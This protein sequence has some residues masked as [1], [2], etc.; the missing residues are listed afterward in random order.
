MLKTAPTHCSSEEHSFSN[1]MTYLKFNT[2]DVESYVPELKA[3]GVTVSELV[4]LKDWSQTSLGPKE[5]WSDCF[6]WT[7]NLVLH[8]SFPMAIYYGE[9]DLLLYNQAWSA[10]L[11]TKHPEAFGEPGH[12][13]W[14]EIWHIM[15]PLI[16]KAYETGKGAFLENQ[17]FLLQRAGYEEETWFRF[18]IS[19]IFDTDGK[20][21]GALNTTFEQTQQY[22]GQRRLT[23]LNEVG[24][25]TRVAQNHQEACY[26]VTSALKKNN[27]DVPW[28]MIYY[29]YQ[30]NGSKTLE[31]VTSSF[32]EDVTDGVINPC[33]PEHLV[34][35]KDNDD[36]CP[37]Y[38][39]VAKVAASGEAELIR[40][41]DGTRAVFLPLFI[42]RA[43]EGRISAVMVCGLHTLR[44][45]DSDYQDFF[46]HLAAYVTTA[47][48]AGITCEEEK[49]QIET[50]AE[51]NR[52]KTAFFQNVS[53]ELRT[54]L[55]LILSP[56][57]QTL[58][59]HTLPPKAR[60]NMLMVQ[61]NARRLL[62]LVNTLLEFS[63]I[64]AG[65]NTAA[66]QQTNISQFT[67]ELLSSFESTAV[68]LGVE[69][70][71]N[72]PEMI[73]ELPVY[74]DQD[75]WEKILLN[76]VSNAFKF[77]KSGIVSVS[78]KPTI[79]EMP[80][81][82]TVEAIQLS[83]IDTGI[84]ISKED[85]KHL[86][87]RFYCV[88][89]VEARSYEGTG[90]GLA[91]VQELVR[92]HLGTIDVESKEL[93][94][95][96]FNVTI[97]TGKS[98]ISPEFIVGD[99]PKLPDIRIKK[100]A[101]L[102]L[103][104]MQQWGS[105]TTDSQPRIEEHV[106]LPDS[107]NLP[108]CTLDS[109]IQKPC[110]LLADD[111]SDMR[112]YIYTLLEDEFE[113][114]LATNGLEALE[115]IN[116][117]V[118]DLVLSDVMMPHL[119]GLGLLKAFRENPKTAT[120]P[121]IFLSAR[122]GPAASAEGVE[123]GAD[124]YLIKPFS[125]QELLARVRTNVIL[126]KLRH[127][128]LIQQRMQ[129]ECKQMVL[130]ISGKIRARFGLED[131]LQETADEVR[132]AL[133]AD[134]I[135]IC[136]N[137][138]DQPKFTVKA[139]ALRGNVTT[140]S[141][142]NRTFGYS[143]DQLSE[144]F[145][146]I[147]Q[148]VENGVNIAT[149]FPPDFSQECAF[150][151]IPIM[152]DDESWG[153]ITARH[154]PG[155]EW[156]ELQCTLIQQ[157]AT[158]VALAI[159]HDKL[160][161]EK[162]NQ[163]IQMEAVNAANRAKSVIL[164]NTSHEIRTP[165]NAIIG[166]VSA[167][168]DTQ[169]TL[170]QR[171]MLKIMLTASDVLLRV[172]NDIL[173]MAKLEARKIKLK[174]MDFSLSDLLQ[175]TMNV[176]SK[177]KEEKSLKLTCT[178]EPNVPKNVIGDSA[179]VQ[180]VLMN[181]L[182]NAFK[183]TDQGQVSIH[184]ERLEPQI[185]SSILDTNRITLR[186]RVTD[187]G[188]GIAKEAINKHLFRSFHQIDGSMTRKYDGVGLGLAICKE[189]VEIGEGQIGVE[190]TLGEGSSFWFTWHFTDSDPNRVIESK[191]LDMIHTQKCL[192]IC[193]GDAED[194]SIAMLIQD[195]VRSHVQAKTY[196]EG[197]GL[198]KQ[199]QSTSDPFQCVFLNVTGN[200]AV[201][202]LSDT[203]AK[204]KALDPTLHI[205]LIFPLSSLHLAQT[206]VSQFDDTV[207]GISMPVTKFKLTCA[208]LNFYQEKLELDI[209][210][211][212]SEVLHLNTGPLTPPP[213]DSDTVSPISPITT[214]K[215]NSRK[216]LNTSAKKAP[217]GLGKKDVEVGVVGDAV[218]VNGRYM[219]L[220]VED[221]PVNMEVVHRQLK[222]LGYRST[223][224]KNGAEAVDLLKQAPGD[225]FSLVLMDCAMPIKDGFE[226]TRDVRQLFDAPVRDI[227]IVALSASCIE[228][229]QKECM[230]SGMNDFLA[231]PVKLGELNQMLQKWLTK[232]CSEFQETT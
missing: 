225:Q 29:P 21:V 94:G 209:K 220:V 231:K 180:Q 11:G 172:V 227:P 90:I 129:T 217:G 114:L 113:V 142:L 190:S 58:H 81:G 91:L 157:I 130:N 74:V 204:L 71:I 97:P 110:V 9:D 14:A 221:N 202:S 138:T 210:L 229:T 16:T 69:F 183:F 17:I 206:V 186:F 168:E 169:L 57:E 219:I 56:I 62:K 146:H 47:I 44:L 1:I 224:A 165:L 33:I 207:V 75:M 10:I 189:L 42:S 35:I 83:V 123:A 32:G 194:T 145:R 163:E 19:P 36:T 141:F 84:G 77:T 88:R 93:V 116:F 108:A 103:D 4:E 191:Y 22:I 223:G 128:L 201:N 149:L 66:F 102:F 50:L 147:D 117:R 65:K 98:H 67:R 8:S 171:E 105:T 199:T 120:I 79:M 160:V 216:L 89:S 125:A 40:L 51:L 153:W 212:S 30:S 140:S 106:S 63:K 151:G 222:R 20:V 184:V 23:A 159:S 143:S 192:T 52:S 185:E 162:I 55:P 13:V 213:H 73:T 131:I 12:K 46:S 59:D 54:P 26:S 18:S 228:S 155:L 60:K 188:I 174:P 43:P 100:T 136:H 178:C 118:P 137:V 161:S 95:T 68:T 215:K 154:V 124:D 85:M 134:C 6:K 96:A 28:S 82:E 27:T 127:E 49:K 2:N 24:K 198:L 104:E 119:D 166:L 122:A 170:E 175:S 3:P 5:N 61:R 133:D 76:L 173:D 87:D 78:L 214:K 101:T 148:T 208:L 109:S 126:S 112:S 80:D 135:L 179:R 158:Q 144:P 230:T 86:F 193:A 34:S 150:I 38:W 31:L 203:V 211:K 182:S 181:L 226:A 92:F 187:T 64:E 195:L 45:L 99:T 70:V 111:N 121:I 37:A 25:L 48:K 107:T 197:L 156:S 196:S 15:K 39:P 53:H 139:E 167:F 152:L 7:L 232:N 115:I 41:P 200:E 218:H 205:L 72:V 164:A 132:K 177:Q 176:F